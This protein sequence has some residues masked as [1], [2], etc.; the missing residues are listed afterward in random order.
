MADSEAKGSSSTPAGPGLDDV[1]AQVR[2]SVHTVQASI[3]EAQDTANKAIHDVTATIDET[4][5]SVLNTIG[6]AGAKKFEVEQTVEEGAKGDQ[7]VL[8]TRSLTL[9]LL[10]EVRS[11]VNYLRDEHAYK[12][13]AATM[14]VPLASLKCN[15]IPLLTQRRDSVCLQL[16]S[17]QCS[18]TAY[19]H[20]ARCQLCCTQHFGANRNTKSRLSILDR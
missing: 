2:A 15:F 17:V 10:A 5:S 1:S 7:S 11:V 14:F 8:L 13:M 19:F 9:R 20:L 12:L 4:K 3:T 16:V 18:A 6:E